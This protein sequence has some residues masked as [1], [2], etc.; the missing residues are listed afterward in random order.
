MATISESTT[1]TL[2]VD[3]ISRTFTWPEFAE[4]LTHFDCNGGFCT[5]E[6]ARYGAVDILWL[7][8]SAI[9]VFFMQAGFTFLEVGSVHMKNTKNILTK[10]LGDATIGALCFYL[11]GYAF[12]FGEGNSFIGDNGFFLHDDGF[13]KDLPDG[14]TFNGSS[15]AFFFFQ[16]AFAATAA[17][18]V[19]GA[20]AE[21]VTFLAYCCYSFFLVIF[22]YPVVV[23][24][25][26]SSTGWA[27]AFQAVQGDKL[28]DVGVIGTLK[29]KV[30]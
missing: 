10:N 21:R 6:I 2:L 23:H 29:K 22:I 16:W 30:N 17:T 12:A 9:L 18:I 27:S 25:G 28:F 14:R 24:W 26:W 15:Y 3:G 4:A 20:V 13:V 7:L 1:V 11:L 8:F 19:S 5:T